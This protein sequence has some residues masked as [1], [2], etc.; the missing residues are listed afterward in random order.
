[1]GASLVLRS[2]KYSKDK[3]IINK[4]VGIIYSENL[5]NLVLFEQFFLEL[6]RYYGGENVV[7]FCP[8]QITDFFRLLKE[9]QV[10]GIDSDL[11]GISKRKELRNLV[12]HIKFE[13]LLYPIFNGKSDYLLLAKQMLADEKIAF[14][15]CG[16]ITDKTQTRY[17][18]FNRIIKFDR[19]NDLLCKLEKTLHC[20]GDEG[21]KM[22]L[23]CVPV[24]KNQHICLPDKYFAIYIN[25]DQDTDSS[26]IE[27]FYLIAHSVQMKLKQTCIICGLG[28]NRSMLL[29]CDRFKSIDA[30]SYVNKLNSFEL[31]TVISNASAVVTNQDFIMDFALATRRISV[32]LCDS[33]DKLS[34]FDYIKKR[35]E[36]QFIPFI[37]AV[38]KSRKIMLKELYVY[39]EFLIKENHNFDEYLANL[40]NKN[41]N[42][43]SRKEVNTI[44]WR[45]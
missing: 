30:H 4:K 34:R 26:L 23:P 1:M 40:K 17:K 6:K 25:L 35:C 33:I 9:I 19:S 10:V 39:N 41:D 11:F 32:Y 16:I 38:R 45:I 12:A 28:E 31:F 36:N 15:L 20:I 7:I 37:G 44:V 29:F 22:S 43:N 42:R 24:F 18:V 5:E 2:M 27:Y 3:K 8:T 13:I 14:D 21:F